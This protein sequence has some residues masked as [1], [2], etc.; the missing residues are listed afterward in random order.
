MPTRRIANA[1][2]E[3]TN[4]PA[5]K[6]QI[7]LPVDSDVTMFSVV[8]PFNLARVPSKATEVIVKTWALEGDEWIFAGGCTYMDGEHFSRRFGQRELW[9]F[10]AFP[11]DGVP[12]QL[13]I[14]VETVSDQP[15][16]CHVDYFAGTPSP[17]R[18]PA[19]PVP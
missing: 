1:I 5:G 3:Q 6:R 19:V 2:D 14:E 18:R 8:F 4:V 16:T 17:E 9:S 13:R 11:F 15:I 10:A 12:S 7:E